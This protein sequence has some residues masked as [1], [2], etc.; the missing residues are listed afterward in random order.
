M[1]GAAAPTDPLLQLHRLGAA[2]AAARA[3]K[4]ERKKSEVWLFRTTEKLAREG[5][6]SG[7]EP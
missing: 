3:G 4:G 7:G 2:A 5:E 6:K 1:A